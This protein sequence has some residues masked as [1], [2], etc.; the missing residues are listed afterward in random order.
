MTVPPPVVMVV[1]SPNVLPSKRGFHPGRRGNSSQ[2][3]TSFPSSHE[4]WR[5]GTWKHF[6]HVF[7]ST[8]CLCG[9]CECVC[10]RVHL[11]VLQPPRRPMYL[12]KFRS[13]CRAAGPHGSSET[14]RIS[15]SL[16]V[17]LYSSVGKSV[18]EC[19]SVCVRG[20]LLAVT[21]STCSTVHRVF[22]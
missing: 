13:V 14:D 15:I 16:A 12:Q 3:F 4:S 2:L 22:C 21:I 8:C 11:C 6:P 5:E 10:A 17:G 1:C 9:L 19:M 7:R 20:G 18:C